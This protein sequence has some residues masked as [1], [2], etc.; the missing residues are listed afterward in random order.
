[1]TEHQ[2]K[3]QLWQT[4]DS[5]MATRQ[6]GQVRQ[7]RQMLLVW[8]KQHPDDYAS[9]DVNQDLVRME[10]TLEI[11]EAQKLVEPVAA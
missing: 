11:I 5:L 4:I 3:E 1:M 8:L 9:L 2:E 7:A 6:L 10:G